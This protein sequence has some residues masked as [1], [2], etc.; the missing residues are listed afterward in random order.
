MVSDQRAK[1][2]DARTNAL[3]ANV[4]NNFLLGALIKVIRNHRAGLEVYIGPDDGVAD[5]VQVS[6]RRGAEND[7][8]LELAAWPDRDSAIEK[9]SSTHVRSRSHETPG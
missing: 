8:G 2:H 4:Q 9:H 7:C 1:F 3:S 6:E 5:E